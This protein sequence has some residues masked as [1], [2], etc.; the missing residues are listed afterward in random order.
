MARSRITTIMTG[1]VGTAALFGTTILFAATPEHGTKASEE[2]HHT[3][4]SQSVPD[5]KELIGNI[6]TNYGG[7]VLGIEREHHG[8]GGLYEVELLGNNG[9]EQEFTVNSDGQKVAGKHHSGKHHSS[10]HESS[11]K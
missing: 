3:Q 6:E 2:M 7:K 10:K 1:L 8:K 4:T 5:L 11:E 9:H